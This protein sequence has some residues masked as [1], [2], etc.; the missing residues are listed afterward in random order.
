MRIVQDHKVDIDVSVVSKIQDFY[1]F[2][3]IRDLAAQLC[4]V[5]KS[6]DNCE[7]DKCGIADACHE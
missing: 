3:N 4:P 7:S 1:L 5:P 6:L 2:R